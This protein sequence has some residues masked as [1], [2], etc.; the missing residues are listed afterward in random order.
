MITDSSLP[1]VPMRRALL[2]VTERNAIVYRDQ[3]CRICQDQLR[4]N[5]RLPLAIYILNRPVTGDITRHHAMMVC[6]AC[7]HAIKDRKV[8]VSGDAE[9]IGSLHVTDSRD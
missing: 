4:E 2:R 3:H 8:G 1:P 5:P 6:R 9:T 7:L